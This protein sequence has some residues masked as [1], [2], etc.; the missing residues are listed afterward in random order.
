MDDAEAHDDR[1]VEFYV[2]WI[3]ERSVNSNSS[4]SSDSV[5]IDDVNDDVAKAENHIIAEPVRTGRN[6]S[7]SNRNGS[8]KHGTRRIRKATLDPETGKELEPRRST[9]L[10]ARS[11]A[12]APALVFPARDARVRRVENVMGASHASFSV[13][14]YLS[15]EDLLQPSG[16]YDYVQTDD[17][18]D[19]EIK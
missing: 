13:E 2:H 5:V 10:R 6:N 17:S 15:C 3:E 1:G 19:G 8:P 4:G 18:D 9:R 12:N 11:T 14:D 16:S 7:I